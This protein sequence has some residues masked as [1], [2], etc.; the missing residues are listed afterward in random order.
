ML[1]ILLFHM[2]LT[3]ALTGIQLTDG[4]AWRVHVGSAHI[5]D[6]L[7]GLAGWLNSLGLLIGV[8]TC[9][10]SI[11]AVSGNFGL[12]GSFRTLN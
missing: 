1:A 10:L 8:T 12:L 6:A 11:I 5:L 7:A 2:A 3:K 4:L 9:G